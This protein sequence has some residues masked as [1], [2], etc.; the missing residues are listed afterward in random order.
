MQALGF[1]VADPKGRLCRQIDGDSFLKVD[2]RSRVRLSSHPILAK[3]F[4]TKYADRFFSLHL[5][6]LL[7]NPTDFYFDL[8]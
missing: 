2:E 6:A 8:Y 7:A 3:V 4:F 5:F 1:C